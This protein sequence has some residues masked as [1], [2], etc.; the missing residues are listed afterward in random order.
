MVAGYCCVECQR[1]DWPMHK[2]QCKRNKKFELKA[3][4][5]ECPYCLNS[6]FGYYFDRIFAG[7]EM[8]GKRYRM[9]FK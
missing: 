7:N 5:E 9:L 3:Q 2:G 6:S 4:T 8:G 1:E